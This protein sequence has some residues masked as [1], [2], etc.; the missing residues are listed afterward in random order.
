MRGTSV[1]ESSWISL[2]FLADSVRYDVMRPWS[3]KD[4]TKRDSAWPS[5][6]NDEQKARKTTHRVN[7]LFLGRQLLLEVL[8]HEPDARRPVGAE[9]LH[10]GN[11]GQDLVAVNLVEDVEDVDLVSREEVR[12]RR[13]VAQNHAVEVRSG[14]TVA[15]EGLNDL[16]RVGGGR[17]RGLG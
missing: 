16:G 4:K 12:T 6:P 3:C 10:D 7:L 2:R 14:V 11:R 9:E 1:S 17:R 15:M 5:Q 13:E 8:P